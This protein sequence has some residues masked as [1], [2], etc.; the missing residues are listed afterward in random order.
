MNDAPYFPPAVKS[1]KSQPLLQGADTTRDPSNSGKFEWFDAV[2]TVRHQVLQGTF[3][4]A[5][6]GWIMDVSDI[7]NLLLYHHQRRREQSIRPVMVS[8]DA[9]K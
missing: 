4:S 3:E 8:S 5:A 7:V 9:L 2:G 1:D 6:D